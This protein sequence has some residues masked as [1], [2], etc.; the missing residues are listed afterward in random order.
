MT[1]R[2]RPPDSGPG[3]PPGP[4]SDVRRLSPCVRSGNAGRVTRPVAQAVFAVPDPEDLIVHS[5][6]GREWELAESTIEMAKARVEAWDIEVGL[7]RWSPPPGAR[8]ELV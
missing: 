4:V 8:P 1:A 3:E 2:T 6:H 7:Q 5:P